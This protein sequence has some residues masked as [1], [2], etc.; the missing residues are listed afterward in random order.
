MLQMQTSLRDMK[1]VTRQFPLILSIIIS[2][3]IYKSP[4]IYL[5][6]SVSG[7]VLVVLLTC[8]R[9]STPSTQPVQSLCYIKLGLSH[10]LIQ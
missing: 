4:N 3:K 1:Q 5:S 7:L 2:A 10:H 8:V 6:R 9:L